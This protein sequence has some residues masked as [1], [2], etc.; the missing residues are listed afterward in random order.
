M[1]SLSLP[2]ADLI[3]AAGG[4]GGGHATQRASDEPRGP[5]EHS[6]PERGLPWCSV[7][8][9]FR[10]G[11]ERTLFAARRCFDGRP[12]LTVSIGF[13]T[14]TLNTLVSGVS[15]ETADTH[16]LPNSGCHKTKGGGGEQTSPLHLLRFR[17]RLRR[18]R[19]RGPGCPGMGGTRLQPAPARSPAWQAWVP[20]HTGAP[21]S[22]SGLAG[23]LGG[24]ARQMRLVGTQR[25]SPP[26][27]LPGPPPPSFPGSRTPHVALDST[28]LRI[29]SPSS[30]PGGLLQTQ[31]LRGT[32]LSGS[33][34]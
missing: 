11:T 27:S 2:L 24:A 9:R 12:G 13:L 3:H 23:Q 32:R 31:Q 10:P 28:I 17:V 33:S 29:N 34:R 20:H 5:A 25:D 7:P 6:C 26:A 16:S 1:V 15:K 19:G 14:E 4:G 18:K 22:L 30:C 21:A 8:P